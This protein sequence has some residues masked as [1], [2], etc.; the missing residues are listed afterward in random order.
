VET[1]AVVMI[2][3]LSPSSPT[4]YR[5]SGRFRRIVVLMVVTSLFMNIHQ[6]E[7]HSFPKAPE[8]KQ[9]VNSSPSRSDDIVS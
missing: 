9:I 1:A 8:K 4:H 6:Q 7:I 2:E 3:K 5:S